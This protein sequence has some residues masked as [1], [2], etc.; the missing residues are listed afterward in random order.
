MAAGEDTV[1]ATAEE[2]A[3][4]ATNGELAPTDLTGEEG[5]IPASAPKVNTRS[6]TGTKPRP[7]AATKS[8]RKTRCKTKKGRKSPGGDDEDDD[9]LS[10]DDTFSGPI[11][12]RYP[13]CPQ[14]FDSVANADIHVKFVHGVEARQPRPG[15]ASPELRP[16]VSPPAI[17]VFPC[18]TCGKLCSSSEQLAAHSDRNHRP[19][20]PATGI[21]TCPLQGCGFPCQSNDELVRHV[22]TSHAHAS[23]A[24]PVLGGSLGD[25]QPGPRPAA[26]RTGLNAPSRGGHFGP[27]L[28]PLPGTS[29]ALP[30]PL[31]GASFT[32]AP[33]HYGSI[34]PAYDG[35]YGY[36]RELKSGQ[37]RS[38]APRA[39]LNIAWPHEAFDSVMGQRS[40]TY[41]TLSAPA[42]AAGCLAMLFPT[43][44]FQQTPEPVQVYLEHLS[45]L[46]HSLAY[47]GNL[48]AVLDYHASVLRL[49]EA[50]S[51][52]WSR[53]HT[54]LLDGLRV[55][56]LALL[57][58]S[59]AQPATSAATPAASAKSAK[60]KASRD[61]ASLIVCSD[62]SNGKCPKTGD[63]DAVRHICWS[64]LAYRDSEALHASPACPHK[65]K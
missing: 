8:T 56:F 5:T 61:K 11:P 27:S 53:A 47:S 40:Y 51:L 29:F 60:D 3:R 20:R 58:S 4:Q 19:D 22:L 59:P 48:K 6:K 23:S 55:N 33:G 25:Q 49:V 64:C 63:H 18:P 31:P 54:S 65:R 7:K 57:R 12:C 9:E 44:E 13:G 26:Y 10:T 21:I 15:P 39:R 32:P 50:G 1:R 43:P 2:L 36:R 30:S 24:A 38:C 46:F 16:P 62:F 17:T 28:G 52:T 41:A 42:L 14:T 35:G 45:V 34:G 37:E